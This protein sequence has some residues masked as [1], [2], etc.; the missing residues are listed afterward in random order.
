[1]RQLIIILII[2]NLD[3]AGAYG[4]QEWIGFIAV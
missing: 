2:T 4:I 3:K 1:M